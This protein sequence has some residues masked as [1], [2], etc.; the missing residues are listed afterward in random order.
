MS[1]PHQEPLD[2]RSRVYL[3]LL[4]PAHFYCWLISSLLGI[5]WTGPYDDHQDDA[6]AMP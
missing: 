4:M 1:S 5:G 3:F 2:V 6:G